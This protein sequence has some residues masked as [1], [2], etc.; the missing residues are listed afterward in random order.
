MNAVHTKSE[1][2]F[3]AALAQPEAERGAFV[4][5]G[6]A[7]DAAV[8]AATERLLQ[9]HRGVGD[10]MEAPVS[11]AAIESSAGARIGRYRLLKKLGEGGVGLVFLAEQEE[12]FRR[13]V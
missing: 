12:P 9:A 8:R 1:E 10:F 4:E 5:L 6:C 13:Q 7:G 11:L 2:L 3:L